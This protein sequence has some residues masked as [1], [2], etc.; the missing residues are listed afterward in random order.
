M[1]PVLGVLMAAL[2][3][4]VLLGML[5]AGVWAH[6]AGQRAAD[7]A[8]LAAARAMRDAY[9][10]VFAPPTLAG[11][12]NPAHLPTAAYVALGRRVAVATAGRNGAEEVAVT[13]PGG[14]LA[15]VRVR[16]DVRDPVRVGPAQAVGLE[17][18]AE[19]ELL[20]PGM[21]P[22][23]A[24]GSGEYR[25]P[26]AFRDGTPMRPD[27]AVA[28]DRM[29]AAARRDGHALVV[30]AASAPTPSRRGSSRRAPTRAGSPGPAPRCTGSG[31]SWTSARRPRTHGSPPTRGD[32]TSS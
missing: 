23:A 21:L 6:G 29:A 7:L 17:A 31:R 24:G 12:R 26:L 25:G 5:A 9:P 4:A 15:P 22:G 3:G 18:T 11:R 20:A 10:R 19:A 32:S 8:A 30:A 28:Y 13:F 1:L 27:V 14:G 16:V 2:A